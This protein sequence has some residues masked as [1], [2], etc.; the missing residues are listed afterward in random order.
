MFSKF[1][2]PSDQLAVLSLWLRNF[3]QVCTLMLTILVM[4]VKL[5]HRLIRISEVLEKNTSRLYL[6]IKTSSPR[7][8][9]ES[10]RLKINKKHIRSW[11][12][13]FRAS[14]RKLWDLKRTSTCEREFSI[15]VKVKSLCMK[16][17]TRL[18]TTVKKK[19]KII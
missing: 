8:L 5:S 14:S 18:I 1:L 2:V 13:L 12:R 15:N 10:P 17:P 16:R 9:K 3:A 19:L 4:I 7:K 11:L 6:I